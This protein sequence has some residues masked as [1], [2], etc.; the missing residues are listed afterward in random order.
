MTTEFGNIIRQNT[1]M[2]KFRGVGEENPKFRGVGEENPEFRRAFEASMENVIS[3]LTDRFGS[4]KL[5]DESVT[6]S[7]ASEECDVGAF[8]DVYYWFQIKR[9]ACV[10][11][12]SI[13]P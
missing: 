7:R 11:T 5:K 8:F 4:M 10:Q 1:K 9:Y 12:A 3:L 6:C 13:A 2:A